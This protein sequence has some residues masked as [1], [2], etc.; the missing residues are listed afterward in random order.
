M[1]LPKWSFSAPRLCT[2]LK[3]LVCWPED[4]FHSTLLQNIMWDLASSIT[5]ITPFSSTPNSYFV[6]CHVA[7]VHIDWPNPMATFRNSIPIDLPWCITSYWLKT[8]Q[9]FVPWCHLRLRKESRN[10]VLGTSRPELLEGDLPSRRL[11]QF[12]ADMP[13]SPAE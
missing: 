4:F 2:S 1:I 8:G 13:A 11:G 7:V 5:W 12:A 6:S 10:F 9:N 3:S